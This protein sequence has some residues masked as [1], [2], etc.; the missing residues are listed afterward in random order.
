MSPGGRGKAAK[1]KFRNKKASATEHVVSGPGNNHYKEE[2]VD[3]LNEHSKY[4]FGGPLGAL[5]TTVGSPLI[6]FYL[7]A[8]VYANE[9]HAMY[10]RSVGAA[11][12]LSTGSWNLPN[13]LLPSARHYM[14]Y[15]I[16]VLSEFIMA[17][18]MPGI[19]VLG[20][21]IKVKDSTVRLKY[22]CNALSS[23]YALLIALP[24]LHYTGIYNLERITEYYPQYLIVSSIAGIAVSLVVYLATLLLGNGVRMS[25]NH[26]YDFFVGAPLN[27]R[28]GPV[29]LKMFAEI[30]ISWP[31]LF[32]ISLSSLLKSYSLT[33]K[34]RYEIVN[35]LIGH[36]LYANACAKGEDFIPSTWDITYEKWGYMVIFWNMAGVPFFYG[37]ASYYLSASSSGRAVALPS[38]FLC[39]VLVIMLVS[40]CLWDVALSQKSHFKQTQE[41]VAR[42]ERKTI[43]DLPYGKLKSYKSI[44]TACG[45]KLLISGLWKYARKLHYTLDSI[46]M[47]TWALNTGFG[48]FAPYFQPVF[49]VVMLLHRQS[50]DESK[51]KAKYGSDWSRYK[52]IVP[53]KYIP[54]VY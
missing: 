18:V 9:G 26:I 39:S 34:I 51:C 27:P 29:D 14:E 31:L 42:R 19:D 24:V 16:F 52:K 43:W 21:K 32:M 7:W 3:V 1:A 38:W 35:L 53:Y 45:S 6:V 17:W 49:F 11:I 5:L 48:A 12:Q 46:T 20:H 2:G 33:G 36:F 4:E 41:G 10:P 44:S 30:R 28:I 50:R 47:V 23:W 54:Y 15:S 40:Y 25:G 13:D 37:L 8:C 22:K